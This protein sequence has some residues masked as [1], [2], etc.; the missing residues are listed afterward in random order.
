MNFL[1]G[2]KKNCGENTYILN[3]LTI[4]LK[5]KHPPKYCV[6][7]ELFFIVQCAVDTFKINFNILYNTVDCYI[8][9]YKVCFIK[10]FG[11]ATYL[12][13]NIG[14]LQLQDPTEIILLYIMPI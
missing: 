2:K 11:L 5:G 13:I 10:I 3:S 8:Q 12:Y 9:Y 7:F 4:I 1:D 6:Y 14:K